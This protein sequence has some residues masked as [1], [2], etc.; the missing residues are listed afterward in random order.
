[1]TK[2]TWANKKFKHPDTKQM[3][4][5]SSLPYQTQVELNKWIYGELWT[6]KDGNKIST[7]DMKT[8]HIENALRMLKR[9][10]NTGRNGKEFIA[11]F[12]TELE[13]RK[14]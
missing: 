3:V 14:E 5:F 2:E 1:M 7:K 9:K 4:E 10:A 13:S 11:I 6:M 8:S 12:E